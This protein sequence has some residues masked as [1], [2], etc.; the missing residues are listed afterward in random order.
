MADF[1]VSVPFICLG[2]VLMIDGWQT[3]G[4]HQRP[5]GTR[6]W[7][8][9]SLTHRGRSRPSGWPKSDPGARLGIGLVFFVLGILYPFWH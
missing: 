5:L 9:Q 1:V 6:N 3:L 7:F 4:D 2:Y 8:L